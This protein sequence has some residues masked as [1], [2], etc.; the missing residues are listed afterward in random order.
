[1]KLNS[2]LRTIQGMQPEDGSGI[3]PT[4]CFPTDKIWRDAGLKKEAREKFD[5]RMQQVMEQGNI[6]VE[7]DPLKP[8][9][10]KP[11]DT[12]RSEVSVPLRGKL[13]CV[14]PSPPGPDLR[15][16]SPESESVANPAAAKNR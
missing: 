12:K 11:N 1:M 5:A 14:C 6:S 9:D 3:R 4:S 10:L 16:R 15:R 8:S 2:L 13:R 7:F